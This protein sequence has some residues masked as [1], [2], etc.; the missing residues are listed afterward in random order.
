MFNNRDMKCVQQKSNIAKTL[1]RDIVFH[2]EKRQIVRDFII[3]SL[4]GQ[5]SKSTIT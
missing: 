1:I 5:V 3:N 4:L 2:K